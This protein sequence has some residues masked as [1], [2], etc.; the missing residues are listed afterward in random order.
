MMMMRKYIIGGLVGFILATAASANAEGVTKLID[1]VV[2]GVFPVTVEGNS[3]GDAI[4]V[5]DKTY[6]PVREFGEAVGYKVTFTEDREVILTKN[7]DATTPE[8]PVTPQPS[9][10]APTQATGP[11]EDIL[12]DVTLPKEKQINYLV[13]E[14]KTLEV[15]LPIMKHTYSKWD[16]N[17]DSSKEYIKTIAE[18]E[19]RLAAMKTLLEQLQQQ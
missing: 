3:V 18:N 12:V 5:N 6:L 19:K 7:E 14:I 17:A 2:Q 9:P 13:D 16:P 1:Q 10:T 4:V 15:T 11:T 8:V